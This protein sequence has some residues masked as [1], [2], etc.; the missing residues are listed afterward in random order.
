MKIDRFS[1]CQTPDDWRLSSNTLMDENLIKVQIYISDL[2]P[3]EFTTNIY[4][5]EF[6]ST[7]EL[8][9]NSV[10]YKIGTVLINSEYE[11]RP[12]DDSSSSDSAFILCDDIFSEKVTLQGNTQHGYR[13][14]SNITLD[15]L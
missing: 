11:W 6:S 3:I 2:E 13:E 8:F 9:G 5:V 1:I 4:V 14:F 12:P 7:Q 10:D 15:D